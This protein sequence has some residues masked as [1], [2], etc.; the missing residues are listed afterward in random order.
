MA[1][2]SM[3]KAERELEAKETADE[4]RRARERARKLQVKELLA[5]LG[6]GL[7]IGAVKARAPS[8]IT[9][10]GPGGRVKLDYVLA[11]AGGYLAF[12]GKNGMREIGSAAAVVG[13]ARLAEPY[14]EQLASGF[15]GG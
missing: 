10:F 3:T 7:A 4:R 13:L 14:G 11:G 12:K 2:G 5:G 9:G 15:G 1:N 8:L 6:V